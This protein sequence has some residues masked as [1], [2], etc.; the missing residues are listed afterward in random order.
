MLFSSEN[1]LEAKKSHILILYKMANA[2]DKLALNED[3]MIRDIAEK[4]GLSEDDIQDIRD[5]PKSIQFTLPKSE[6]ERLVMLYHLLF[7]MRI[8]GE[9]ADEELEMLHRLGFRLGILPA[10]IQDL[11]EIM[12]KHLDEQLPPDQMLLAVRKYRN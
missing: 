3:K 2:D 4:M 5:N 10:L 9:I 7:L 6:D 12:I 1:N 11:A 8:D